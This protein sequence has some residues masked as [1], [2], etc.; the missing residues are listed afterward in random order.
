M[1]WKLLPQK[2][3]WERRKKRIRKEHGPEKPDRM[4]LHIRYTQ[5]THT[6]LSRDQWDR[7]TISH[8]VFDWL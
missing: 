1:S 5:K 2:T 3:I 6:L 8:D 4:G 7:N